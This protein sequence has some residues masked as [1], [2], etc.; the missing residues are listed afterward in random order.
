METYCTVHVLASDVLWD[1]KSMNDKGVWGLVGW[2]HFR[3]SFFFFGKGKRGKRILAF[4]FF[5]KI[6]SERKQKMSAQLITLREKSLIATNKGGGG[7]M[8]SI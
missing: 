1:A 2:L 5:K 3:G 4:V 7:G 6:N 8:M